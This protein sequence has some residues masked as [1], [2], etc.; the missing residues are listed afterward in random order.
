[1]LLLALGF[2]LV[3]A[4]TIGDIPEKLSGKVER[5]ITGDK[6]EAHSSSKTSYGTDINVNSIVSVIVNS[7]QGTE[8]ST[9]SCGN[10]A[11]SSINQPNISGASLTFEANIPDYLVKNKIDL[12]KITMPK[13]VSFALPATDR[14][15]TSYLLTFENGEKVIAALR[16]GKSTKAGF[17]T[18]VEVFASR[19]EDRV[20]VSGREQYDFQ[21]VTELFFNDAPLK[22]AL[23]S[24]KARATLKFRIEP[25]GNAMLVGDDTETTFSF[26]PEPEMVA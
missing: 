21:R 14:M 24:R 26:L 20:K 5:G 10:N 12:G 3:N 23:S 11:K 6:E 4:S 1:M 2:S 18:I 13:D 25:D 22:K 7:C 8:G 9:V 16:M 19:L 15:V 17:N